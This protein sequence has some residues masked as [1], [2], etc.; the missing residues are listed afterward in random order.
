MLLLLKINNFFP[1]TYLQGES[2]DEDKFLSYGLPNLTV[3]FEFMLL[4]PKVSP[5]GSTS[6]SFG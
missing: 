4:S 1:N 3:L 2:L 5:I 6:L